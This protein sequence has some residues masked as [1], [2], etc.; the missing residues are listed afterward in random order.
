MQ[1]RLDEILKLIRIN[2]FLYDILKFALINTR[3]HT[4]AKT[5]QA[6]RARCA[7]P[8]IQSSMIYHF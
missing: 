7:S 8:A 3:H 5:E 1:L 6:H 4:L 2:I